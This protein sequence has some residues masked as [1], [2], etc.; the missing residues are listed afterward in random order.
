MISLLALGL[1]IIATVLS[2]LTPIFL[3]RGAQRF[4][5]H[6]RTVL[7]EPSRIFNPWLVVGIGLEIVSSLLNVAALVGSQ[8]STITPVT[9]LTYIWACVF[10]TALL[11]E[12]MTVRKW[13]GVAVII[14]GVILVTIA[15]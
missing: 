9:S 6:P 7:R 12:K 11:K 4:S 13:F 3:K 2:G 5:I 15:V 14:A 1:V 10:S 8:L